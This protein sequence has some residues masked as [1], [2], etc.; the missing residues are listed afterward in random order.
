[1]FY[2]IQRVNLNRE[3][4]LSEIKDTTRLGV[5]TVKPWKYGRPDFGVG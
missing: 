1:M 5:T 4:S 2:S 3:K